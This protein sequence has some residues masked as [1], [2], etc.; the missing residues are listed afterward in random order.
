M[1]AKPPLSVESFAIVQN[2]DGIEQRFAP[3]DL[4]RLDAYTKMA[5]LAAA[6]AL[7]DVEDREEIGLIVASGYGPVRRTCAFMDS[8]IDDG[9]LCASPLA[10][11][12]SVHNVV[13]TFITMLLS[14]R[15]PCLSIS[16]FGSSFESALLTARS[17]L[18][19]GRCR[20]VLVGAVD[21]IHPV[22]RKLHAN[23]FQ[24]SGAAFFL[25]SPEGSCPLPALEKPGSA[26]NPSAP[27]FALARRLTPLLNQS[28]ISHI[29]KD[30]LK[31]ELAR[32]KRDVFAV[33]TEAEPA[34]MLEQYSREERRRLLG[35]L[36]KLFSAQAETPETVEAAVALCEAEYARSRGFNFRTSG[37]T[38][39][40][41]DCI[42]SEAVIR[43]EIESLCFLFREIRRVVCL[44]P[45]HHS[46]GFIFGLQIPKRLGIPVQYEAPLPLLPWRDG[47]QPGDLLVA[48]PMFLQQW[49]DSGLEFPPGITVLTATAPCPDALHEALHRRGLQ[50][51]IEIYGSS[52][53]GAV[54]WRDAARAPFELLPH[55][56]AETAGGHLDQIRRRENALAFKLPDVAPMQDERHFQLCGRKDKA[57][58]VAGVNVYPAKVEAFLCRHPMVKAC[59]VRLDGEHLKAFVVL[60]DPAQETAAQTA[61]HEY[62]QALSAHE[63]PKK[64]RFGRAIPTTPFG[65]RSDW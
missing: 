36:T 28:A 1:P 13:E 8:I 55:W 51:C 20:K 45:V 65:K 43:E 32:F 10:F 11:S 12:A 26:S 41:V 57:V 19:A 60:V 54:A 42:Q 40:P 39:E 3:K 61:L 38:G 44:V 47:L 4:R 50:R 62:L 6:R 14:L 21:E 46:Y 37:S 5:L 24:E 15:G 7:K 33:F 30:F 52:E 23:V 2:L 58:Q 34:R 31:T 63:I 59:A 29:A 9:P 48:F 22:N 53:G 56:I 18:L 16:Q 17:W 49:V 25:L 27:A 64:I 35:G